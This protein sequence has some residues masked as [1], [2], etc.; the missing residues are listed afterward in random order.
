MRVFERF[1]V[2]IEDG[3]G[4]LDA[5]LVSKPGQIAQQVVRVQERKAEDRAHRHADR[6]T[7]E[8]IVTMLAE[9]HCVG[10]EPRGQADH[11][12]DV[13]DVGDVRA[14]HQRQ[15][16]AIARDDFIEGCA[17]LTAAA[18]DHAGMEF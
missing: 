17:R 15:A 2:G 7:P 4:E 5:P 1:G 11:R 10:P 18:G 6:L 9:D 14:N 13:F 16:V 8:G 12:A 3:G